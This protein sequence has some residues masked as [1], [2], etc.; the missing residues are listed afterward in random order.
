MYIDLH[1]FRKFSNK[2]AVNLFQTEIGLNVGYL[3]EIILWHFFKTII[4]A[5]NQ[6]SLHV[7][8][9]FWVSKVIFWICLF[10]FVEN[11]KIHVVELTDHPMGNFLCQMFFYFY[12]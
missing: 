3:Q 5:W 12:A 4:L 1:L 11:K 10:I 6:E 8:V 9:L 2:D 7:K